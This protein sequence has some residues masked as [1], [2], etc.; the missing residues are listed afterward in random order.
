MRINKILSII[1]TILIIISCILL[2]YIEIKLCNY[3]YFESFKNILI[4]ILSSSI[5]SLLI[6]LSNYFIERNKIINNIISQLCSIYVNIKVLSKYIEYSLVKSSSIN[7]DILQD[8][9][10]TLSSQTELALNIFNKMD[11]SEFDPFIKF[12]RLYKDI[13]RICEFENFYFLTRNIA[14]VFVKEILNYQIYQ[15]KH[16]KGFLCYKFLLD[17]SNRIINL[18]K[19]IYDEDIIFEK[20]LKNFYETNK[21]TPSWNDK[22]LQL[23]QSINGILNFRFYQ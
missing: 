19:K 11:I 5:V 4:G 9:L 12:S 16:H 23:T 13:K 15:N 20:Y 22:Y 21:H 7:I 6:S 14:L 1:C 10:N 18:N 8:V 3:K 2:F 17:F